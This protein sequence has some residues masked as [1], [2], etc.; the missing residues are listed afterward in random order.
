MRGFLDKLHPLFVKGGKLENF[1]ALYEAID[2][3]LYTPGEVTKGASHVRDGIDL[4]R[5]MITVAMALTPCILMACYNT[6]YQANLALAKLGLTETA[7]WRGLAIGALGLGYDPSNILAN[8]FHGFLYWFPV[9]LVTNMV[10]GF[11]EGLFAMVRKHEINEG[12]LVT[13]MLFPLNSS[14]ND[15]TLA[16]C[17]WYFIRCRFR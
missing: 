1:Y 15:P 11:W 10:G 7:G 14:T 8:M 9:F 4:K 2:T 12:F 3:F 16:S 5:I 17:Y 6:G 13:G